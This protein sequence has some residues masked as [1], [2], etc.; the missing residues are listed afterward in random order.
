MISGLF[1]TTFSLVALLVAMGTLYFSESTFSIGVRFFLK[2]E[3]IEL[4]RKTFSIP[5]VV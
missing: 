1:L 3:F 2:E 5:F 4:Y